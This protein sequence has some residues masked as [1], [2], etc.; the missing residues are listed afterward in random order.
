M[1]LLRL[2]T[3]A[4]SRS[5]LAH[6]HQSTV[7]RTSS[8]ILSRLFQTEGVVH[9]E[10]APALPFASEHHSLDED[11]EFD[12]DLTPKQVVD[13]LD[14]Y[15][16]GQAEAKRA[17]ANALRNRWRRRQIASPMKEE[18]VPKNILMIGPTG[19]GKTEIARRLAKLADAPFVKVEATKFTEVGF[20][21]RDVD[22]IV[23]DLVD[24]AIISTRAKMRRQLRADIS[25]AVEDKILDCLVGPV[26]ENGPNT[27]R[28]SFR[29]LYQE[30]QLDERKITIDLPGSRVSVTNMDGP[31]G[32]ALQEML[33]RLDRVIASRKNSGEKREMKVSEARPIIEDMVSERLIS[34]DA[35]QREAIQAVEQDG[36]V[37]IDEI[38]KIVVNQDLRYGADASSEGVQRDLLPIIEG[39][40]VSTKYGNVSTDYIL[41]ICSGAFHQ[42]KPSDMLAELQ[43][44]LPIRVE[45]KGLTANDFFRILTEPE[46]NMIKQQQ[47]L[48][49]TEGVELIFTDA[50]IRQ[51]SQ[52]AEEVNTL[53]DNIGARRLHTILERIL[54][55]ISFSAPEQAKDAIDRGE[56]FTYTVTEQHISN[57]L[58]DLL[59]KKD[60][61]KYIL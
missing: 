55:D 5:S 58:G 28:E 23:R 29:A 13:R 37:F 39:S 45:L 52:V 6:A 48:I 54:E 36:I 1:T 16:V 57:A 34:D 25:R 32:Q 46:H 2:L 49:A 27:T 42:C 61:S 12:T 8:L 3:S 15:I 26:S 40:Q 9:S 14:R 20:H 50:A 41:F 47:A 44:R 11:D 43:G 18:I 56:K 19:C 31:G 24:A 30:G 33:S 21:G 38:D 35:V 17:V 60:L 10:T 51:I 7:A 22:Q 53:V 4:R 59:K